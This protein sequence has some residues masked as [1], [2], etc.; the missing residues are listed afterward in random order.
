MNLYTLTLT[1]QGK[2]RNMTVE[3]NEKK[4]EAQIY[5]QG[6]QCNTWKTAQQCANISVSLKNQE[7]EIPVG[8]YTESL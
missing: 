8:S 6:L 2:T 7:K 3:N 5:V 4:E 1:Q